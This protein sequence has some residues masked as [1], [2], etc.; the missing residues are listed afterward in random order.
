V[1]QRRC[2]G[3][4]GVARH[5]RGKGYN[6]HREAI[7]SGGSYDAPQKKSE[8]HGG[9]LREGEKDATREHRPI[10]ARGKKIYI[11]KQKALKKAAFT[12]SQKKFAA[13]STPRG[14]R[15]CPDHH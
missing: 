9:I 11:A 10:P 15:T 7:S 6:I 8:V 14:E 1:S 12:S 13:L 3:L 5:R 4:K 2:L